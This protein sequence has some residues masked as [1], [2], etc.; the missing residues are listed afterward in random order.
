[1]Y[2]S[3]G[4]KSFGG[5]VPKTDANSLN[6]ALNFNSQINEWLDVRFGADFSTRTGMRGDLVFDDLAYKTIMSSSGSSAS[7]DRLAI[8][9]G[10]DY[11]TMLDKAA[12]RQ[13]DQQIL[14]NGAGDIHLAKGLV[15]TVRG[16]YRTNNYSFGQSAPGGIAGATVADNGFANI[17]NSDTHRWSNEDYLTFNKEF[18]GVKTT[19]VL[20]LMLFPSF[21][22]ALNQSRGFNARISDRWDLT[23]ECIRRYYLGESSP[24]DKCLNHPTNQAFF[25][26][27]LDF[28]GFVDFFFLQDCVT[29]DYSK[30]IMWLDTPLFDTNPIPKTTEDY[31][32]F[33]N[34]E[35][36]FVD[37]RNKRIEEFCKQG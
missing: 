30:V 24:L 32:D 28:K 35:L 2:A 23:L 34:K 12:Y 22:M 3:L 20:G 10:Y 5:I 6:T 8:L 25:N 4:Y 36:T 18:N 17:A 29:E 26:M 13:K 27:F 15:F 19:S 7:A 9:D 37:K 1:M 14:L 31:F 16:D 33:I 11:A 21:R